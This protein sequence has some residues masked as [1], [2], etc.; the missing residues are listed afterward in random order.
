MIHRLMAHQITCS[1]TIFTSV[2]YCTTQNHCI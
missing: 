2:A 1:T